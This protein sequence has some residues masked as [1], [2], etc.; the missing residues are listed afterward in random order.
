MRSRFGNQ[1][2][3]AAISLNNIDD[4]GSRS[5][6]SSPYPRPKLR[7][8]ATFGDRLDKDVS[9]RFANDI[10]LND[11]DLTELSKSTDFSE[12][13]KH[14]DFGELSK[15]TDFSELS[16]SA[17]FTEIA[18]SGFQDT[19]HSADIHVTEVPNTEFPEDFPDKMNDQSLKS[20]TLQNGISPR[21]SQR[22]TFKAKRKNFSTREKAAEPYILP[23]PSIVVSDLPVRPDM[24]ETLLTGTLSHNQT[25]RADLPV[26]NIILSEKSSNI[27]TSERL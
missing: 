26:S 12:I 11:G 19:T 14:A 24:T 18:H 8:R 23:V 15:N 25:K 2:S 4:Y 17:D 13:S 27:I 6:G 7:R 16:K 3:V 10:K 21:E 5:A 1:L 22:R 20:L 9:S